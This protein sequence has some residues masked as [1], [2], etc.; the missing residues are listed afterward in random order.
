METGILVVARLS[1]KKLAVF[2]ILRAVVQQVQG[3]NHSGTRAGRLGGNAVQTHVAAGVVY[4][5]V[6]RLEHIRALI[7]RLHARFKGK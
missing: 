6:R 4:K 2:R 7:L 3:I 1:V 5:H